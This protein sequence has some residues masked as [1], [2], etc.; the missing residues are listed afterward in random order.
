MDY[1]QPAAA[2]PRQPA[3]VSFDG[4]RRGLGLREAIEEPTIRNASFTA[5][6]SRLVMIGRRR[7]VGKFSYSFDFMLLPVGFWEFIGRELA[8]C[9]GDGVGGMRC[10][11]G[12]GP[13]GG[14]GLTQ[15]KPLKSPRFVRDG[16]SAPFLPLAQTLTSEAF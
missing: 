11:K 5:H 12:S 16:S 4:L 13:G 15:E 10:R 14:E 7:S 2:F 6:F 1:A 3:A 9:R 8:G